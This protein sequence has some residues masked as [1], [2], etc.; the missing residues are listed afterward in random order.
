MPK[1][2]AS[3]IVSSEAMLARLG[4]DPDTVDLGSVTF[5]AERSMITFHLLGEGLKNYKNYQEVLEGTEAPVLSVKTLES[6]KK[7]LQPGE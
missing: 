4:L 2:R 6:L 1:H 3:F 7:K 5:D